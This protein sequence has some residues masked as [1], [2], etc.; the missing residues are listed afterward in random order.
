VGYSGLTWD[1]PANL[2]RGQITSVERMPSVEL[3]PGG[4]PV[5]FALGPDLDVDSMILRDP[6]ALRDMT[7]SQFLDRRLYT[8]GL[9]VLHRGK[10]VYETYRNSMTDS[11]RHINHSTTKTLTTML[12][13]IATGEGRLSVDA[14][15]PELVPELADLP[16]WSGITLQHVL[17]M[18]AGLDTEEAYENAD[19]MYW[20][21]AEAV[22]YYTTPQD[23]QIGVLAFIER[24][25]TTVLE[26][27]GQRFNY[28]SYLTNLIPMAVENAYGTPATELLEGRIYRHLGAEQPALLNLDSIGRP[29]VEGQLNLTLRDFAR[30][31]VPFTRDGLAVTGR[32]VVSSAWVEETFR[33]DQARAAA[34]ARGASSADFS[35]YP[36]AQYHNQAWVLDPDRGV[37]AMIGI[38]GQF[39]FIDLT[40]DLVIVGF[41]SFPVQMNRL[42]QSA[43]SELWSRVSRALE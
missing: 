32:R 1:Q 22:G 31:S 28:A 4:P 25:L 40:A 5:P 20:R 6:L 35:A 9:L 15:M 7:G 23:R 39:S 8:D 17:D 34:F 11:D 30:W 19:S 43:M 18:A 2:A 12:V 29:I 41:G 10:L 27:P 42:L 3:M 38:H 21:Y 13:G 37:M 36:H 33:A 14:P 26:P 24:E 16:A